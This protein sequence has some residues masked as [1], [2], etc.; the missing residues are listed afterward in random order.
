MVESGCKPDHVAAI[1]A[2]IKSRTKP[3]WY[4]FRWEVW[5]IFYGDK[6]EKSW[7]KSVDLL[8]ILLLVGYVKLKVI[9]II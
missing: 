1:V 6:L 8:E 2:D 5:L 3:N 4:N 7:I 9:N